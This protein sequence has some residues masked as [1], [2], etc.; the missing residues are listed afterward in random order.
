LGEGSYFYGEGRKGEGKGEV[1]GK[2]GGKKREG[3][4]G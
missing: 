3:R 4:E 1:K 2:E